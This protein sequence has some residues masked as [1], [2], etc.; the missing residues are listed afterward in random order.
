MTLLN[1]LLKLQLF[2]QN[3]YL[4]VFFEAGEMQVKVFIFIKKLKNN[5]LQANACIASI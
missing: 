3:S 2:S 4:S 1:Y 5:R